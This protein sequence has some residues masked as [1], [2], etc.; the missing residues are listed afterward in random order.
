MIGKEELDRLLEETEKLLL[1]GT[2]DEALG[3]IK[4]IEKRHLDDTDRWR[5]EIL[6]SRCLMKLNDFKPAIEISRRVV[7]E[8]KKTSGYDSVVVDA[9]VVVAESLWRLGELDES[10]E[11][12]EA[13]ERT[14]QTVS[15]HTLT[16]GTKMQSGVSPQK[17]AL[18]Y[19]KGE[20]YRFKGDL[21][22]ALELYKQSLVLYKRLDDQRGIAAAFNVLGIVFVNKGNLDQGLDY[23]QQSLTLREEIG[24]KQEIA[25]SLNNVG[26]VNQFLGKLD[27][28][29]T[30]YHRSLKIEEETN[31]KYGTT[32]IMNNIGEIHFIKGDLALALD[33]YERCLALCEELGNNQL[34]ALTLR[35]LGEV[36]FRKGNTDKAQEYYQRSLVIREK[37][38]NKLNISE[39]L[40]SLLCGAISRDSNDEAKKYLRQLQDIN[41][42]EESKVVNLRYRIGEAL[43]LKTSMRARNR[44]KA[45]ELL[46]QVAAEEIVVHDL[47]VVALLSLCDLLLAELHISGDAEV[48][49]EVQAHQSRLLEIA[50]NQ[51]SFWL[52]AET[53]VLQSKLLLLDLNVEEARR[54]LT[55]AQK[56]ADEKG[57]R[58]LAARISNEHDALL[59]ELDTWE[60]LAQR[61]ASLVERTNLARVNE[62][63]EH[64]FKQNVLEDQ[65][66]V[67]E[68]PIMLMVL[69]EDGHLVYSKNFALTA[70]MS[71]RMIGSF[72]QAIQK[73]GHE[74]FSQAL[75]RIKFETYTLLLRSK[76]PLTL[77]YIYKGQSYSAQQKLNE[78]IDDVLSKSDVW[79]PLL[80]QVKTGQTLNPDSQATLDALLS[81]VFVGPTSN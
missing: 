2:I 36:Y 21:D 58:R 78:F 64:M 12:I 60:E 7:E 54:L 41:E 59:E 66:Q 39:T 24:N 67:E 81:E 33:H 20:V 8:S 28:A 79:D 45:E 53:Y 11:V 61:E 75:D 32:Y 76:D 80:E 50:E 3:M 9:S 65:D 70:E 14:F 72:L 51:H 1:E 63:V 68:D 5:C 34:I 13:A 27:T 6:E 56:F 23:Y 48:L 22:Q 49:R 40:F 47:T 74:V 10:L 37:I 30:Y 43:V 31:N 17:A 15:L 18:L 29:L 55:Q 4:S 25:M 52:L 57:L 77:C 46:E 26:V 38:G 73:F 44:A 19:H 35:N 71:D 16:F 69:S 62:Q 42:H